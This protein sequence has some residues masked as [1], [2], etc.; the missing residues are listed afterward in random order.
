MKHIILG[1]T[2][3]LAMTTQAFALSCIAPDMADAFQKASSSDKS[4]VVLKGTFQFEP[5]A[6]SD[7]PQAITFDAD[8]AGR[9]LTTK[10]FTQ[11]VGA[12]VQITLT[13]SAEWCAEMSANT[14]YV[15]FVENRENA[16]FLDVTPCYGFTFKKPAAERVKQLENCARGGACQ[17]ATN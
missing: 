7:T 11:Q 14:E 3:T 16:L 10:G 15:A 1:T 9:L 17:A 13:C 2:L 5:P 8:F 12:D 4:Y 6:P